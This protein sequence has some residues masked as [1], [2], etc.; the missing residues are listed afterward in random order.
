[1]A[2]PGQ[3]LRHSPEKTQRKAVR[4]TSEMKRSS[5]RGVRRVPCL[6]PF[7]D[8]LHVLCQLEAFTEMRTA[9]LTR[10]MFDEQRSV[11][12]SCTIGRLLETLLRSMCGNTS[13]REP[14]ERA[15]SFEF[16]F[17]SGRA[18][19]WTVSLWCSAQFDLGYAR[20]DLSLEI[21]S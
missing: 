15:G 19:G 10:S 9:W 5:N 4:G 8:G 16:G 18:D 13:R 1:M 21:N 3:R 14:H 17:K 2:N 20:R 7:T 11:N 12:K 6:F